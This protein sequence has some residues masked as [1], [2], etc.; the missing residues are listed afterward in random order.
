[1]QYSCDELEPEPSSYGWG[2][3]LTCSVE[4]CASGFRLDKFSFR[5][6]FYS[7]SIRLLLWTDS[8]VAKRFRH[9]T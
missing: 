3:I 4:T 1:M 8:V 7:D 9:C 2:D 5:F 6:F